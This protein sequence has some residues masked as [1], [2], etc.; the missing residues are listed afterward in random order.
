[1]SEFRQ[2]PPAD[3]P[4]WGAGLLFP[5]GQLLTTPGALAACDEAHTSPLA[6]IARHAVGDWGDMDPEDIAANDR[7]LERGGRLFSA[8]NLPTSERLWV[9][10]E[11]DYSATTALLPREY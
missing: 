10:T 3:R 2:P 7:A 9:I 11:A 5:L 1:M 4:E 6:Y 8:Y